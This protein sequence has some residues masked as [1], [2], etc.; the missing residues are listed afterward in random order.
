[1]GSERPR[2]F[3]GA[4]LWVAAGV[5]ASLPG[6]SARSLVGAALLLLAGFMVAWRL[7]RPRAIAAPAPE[8]APQPDAGRLDV[9]MA[10][11]EHLPVAAWV[12]VDEQTPQPLRAV[13][14]GSPRPAAFAIRRP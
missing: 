11:L 1:M 2:L 6:T 8:Q 9:L 3:L 14:A 10:Q 12:L 13:L 5:L 4:L 7:A